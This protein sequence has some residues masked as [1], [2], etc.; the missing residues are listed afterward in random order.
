M[1]KDK[2]YNSCACACA[3]ACVMPAST[4][5]FFFSNIFLYFFFCIRRGYVNILQMC[6]I[7]NG[8]IQIKRNAVHKRIELWVCLCVWMRSVRFLGDAHSL[9]LWLQ[10]R[11]SNTHTHTHTEQIHFHTLSRKA[12]RIV[13]CSCMIRCKYNISYFHF[14][15]LWFAKTHFQPNKMKRR[16][17]ARRRRRHVCLETQKWFAYFSPKNGVG[18]CGGDKYGRSKKRY[19]KASLEHTPQLHCMY[20]TI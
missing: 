20:P 19:I 4:T 11:Y 2:H 3:C 9:L 17:F 10:L 12:Y 13:C 18:W 8:K 14:H 16:V 5:W 15:N 1:I 6:A 7:L